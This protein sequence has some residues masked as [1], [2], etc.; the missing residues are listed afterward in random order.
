MA[1]LETAARTRRST[2]T[3][4]SVVEEVVVWYGALG[5]M[6]EYKKQVHLHLWKW[7]MGMAF[8]LEISSAIGGHK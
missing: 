8:R 1:E 4:A 2:V 7:H 3:G 5:V 6:Y